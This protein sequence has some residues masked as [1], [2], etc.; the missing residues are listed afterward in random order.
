MTTKREVQEVAARAAGVSAD[1]IFVTF[2]PQNRCVIVNWRTSM[3]LDRSQRDAVKR[4]VGGILSGK[5][6][7]YSVAIT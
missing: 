1:E 6:R 7:G 2:E 5:H 4:S 3:L